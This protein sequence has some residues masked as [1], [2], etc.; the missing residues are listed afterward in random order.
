MIR[1]SI[2]VRTTP[3]VQALLH[4]CAWAPNSTAANRLLARRIGSQVTEAAIRV[5]V[6]TAW[7]RLRTRSPSAYSEFGIKGALWSSNSIYATCY[8]PVRRFPSSRRP[9]RP[10]PL[11][12]QVDLVLVREGI[13][14]DE[15]IAR[16]R[17]QHDV[18]RH[19]E[20]L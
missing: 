7:R 12:K 19:R 5:G 3:G 15:V 14:V 4:A 9:I 10:D 8:P 11:P 17:R 18:E 20:A 13:R 2:G 6:M 16:A 1:L